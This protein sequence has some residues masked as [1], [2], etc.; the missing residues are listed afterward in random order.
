MISTTIRRALHLVHASAPT[1]APHLSAA[2]GLVAINNMLYV[3]ADDENHLGVFSTDD[4]SPG[5]LLRVF[6]GTLPDKHKK[7]KALK[8]DLETLVQ[9]PA[10]A[11]FPHGA[12]L[13]L[14]SGSRASRETGVLLTLDVHGAVN[15]PVQHV[16]LSLFYDDLRFEIDGLNIEGM[17]VLG[18]TIR[19]LQRG[20]K[21]S[22]NALIDC[23]LAPFLA[24]ISKQDRPRL[25]KAPRL[26][27]AT[28]GDID[29]VPLCFTDGAPLAQG[30][31]I[32]TAVAENTDN[33][34][35]DGACAGSAIGIIDR[36]GHVTRIQRLTDNHK[37]EGI[38]ASVCADGLNLLLVTDGDDASKPA[39]LLSALLKPDLRRR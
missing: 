3:V 11:G 19:L 13:A 5:N 4:A 2:S 7:R 25:D 30:E 10:F 18:D 36:A 14:G 32:F 31:T 33:S 20:N 27:L 37:V 24:A 26:T 21:G 28:L 35:D 22:A 15:A 1:R 9:L 8:P 23:N 12:L 6:E 38:A 17:V 34:V 16:D 39:L 29:G